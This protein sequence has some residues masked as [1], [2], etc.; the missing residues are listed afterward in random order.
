MIGLFG[1]SQAGWIIPIAAVKDRR[2]AFLVLWSGPVCRVSDELEH[3][4]AS[5]GTMAA[6]EAARAQEGSAPQQVKLI[7][8]YI[9][10]IRAEGT[11][12][13]PQPSLRQ[14]AIPGL[15]L[16][17]GTDVQ[18]PT[19]L[20]ARQL[21]ALI[22]EGRSNFEQRTLPEAAHAMHGAGVEAYRITLD[23]MRAR[24]SADK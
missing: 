22:A 9:A 20:S 16:F 8:G 14:L 7:R 19:E 13:D 17:G 24:A 23:W 3:S 6:E 12:V 5:A 2:V 1:I 18:I 4:I 15:W 10:Q 11:D 21:A